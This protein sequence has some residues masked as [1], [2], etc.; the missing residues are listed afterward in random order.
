VNASFPANVLVDQMTPPPNIRHTVAFLMLAFAAAAGGAGCQ[1][2][3]RPI[4]GVA[5]FAAVDDGLFRGG[6]PSYDGIQQLKSNGVRTVID[7][8][9]DRNP[10]E[11]MWVEEA[12]MAYVNIGTSANRIEP[13]KIATFLKEV[14]EAQKPIFVHCYRGR[15]RTGLEVAV[16][17]IVEQGWSREAAL[18]ELYAHGY[19]WVM[20]PGIARYVRT[21]DPEQFK[22]SDDA[23]G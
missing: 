1:T 3:G 16:Y 2:V 20:F 4:T 15:D 6:Q 21:F 13:A 14:D 12:G 8:R 9:D 17:R 19:Q 18:N 10:S 7:L 23:G 22:K 5:N 11:R